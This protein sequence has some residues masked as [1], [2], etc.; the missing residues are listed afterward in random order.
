MSAGVDEA[1]VNVT[2]WA[3]NAPSRMTEALVHSPDQSRLLARAA[4]TM[5]LVARYER[6]KGLTLFEQRSSYW[7]VRVKLGMD[8]VLA[9]I[10][11]LAVAEGPYGDVLDIGCGR[12]Q[13]GLLLAEA[14]LAR[15][16]HGIDWHESKVRIA[17]AAAVDPAVPSSFEASDVRVAALPSAD[18]IL[19]IDLLHYLTPEE[20]DALLAR[21]ATSARRRILVRDVDPERGSSS[22]LTR[23]WEWVTTFLGWNRGAR[24]SPRSFTEL[25]SVLESH[26]FRVEREPCTTRGLSNV[27]LVA[28]RT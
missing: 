13:L 10:V 11:D 19:L 28:R 9:K 12:G 14:G 15:S 17:R 27:L 6:A 18:T 24:V 20:Q 25:S 16:I 4:A 22:A 5:R 2:I 23:S 1:H 26:G 3:Y 7:Y 8:P 21:A